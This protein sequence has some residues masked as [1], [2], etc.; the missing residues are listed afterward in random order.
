MTMQRKQPAAVVAAIQTL[1]KLEATHGLSAVHD[2]YAESVSQIMAE[3]A[4]S[5]WLD[6]ITEAQK[7]AFIELEPPRSRFKRLHPDD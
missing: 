5:A 4:R 7:D 1:V 6:K 2:V 3:S